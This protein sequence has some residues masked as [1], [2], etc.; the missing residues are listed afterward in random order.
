MH[1]SECVCMFAYKHLKT[2]VHQTSRRKYLKM[3]VPRNPNRRERLSTVDLL[4]L[5]SSDQ[6][7][8]TL[9]ISFAFVTKQAT[10]RRR[11]SVLSRP[12]QL[13]FPGSAIIELN[14]LSGIGSKKLNEEQLFVCP[15]ICTPRGLYYKLNTAVI[16]GFS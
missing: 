4:V 15:K 5:T 8:F 16:Y 9:K 6:L 11:S 1:I 14:N 10:L 12:L 2:N 7:I 3:E 13:A